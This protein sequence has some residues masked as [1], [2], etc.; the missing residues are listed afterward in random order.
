[1]YSEENSSG[2]PLANS[3]WLE[4]HHRAKI[5][6]RIAF[7]KRLEKLQPQKIVDLGCATGLWLE[8]LNEILP[9]D[10]EFIGIDSDV[11]SL[12]IAI[13]RS[14]S[15]SRK[16]S[17]MQLDIEKYATLIPTA[18][19]TLAFN[20]FPY[21]KDLDTFLNVL[22]TKTPHGTLA[23]RQYDGASIRFG[24]MPTSMR[25]KIEQDL[26][27]ATGNSEK[28][29]HYD[30]DRAFMALRNS[31]YKNFEYS[32]ELFERI[33]PFDQDFVPYYKGTMLW[34]CKHISDASAEFLKKWMNEDIHLLN[35]YFYEVDLVALLS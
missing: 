4:N 5:P 23:V 12:E 11:E 3:S 35:R 7:A 14:K 1:M 25:Q 32:F 15:W 13:S 16:T 6:E 29:R 19:L 8:L 21:I 22:A 20:I 31:A 27:L 18:D 9:L 24:P 34:T 10:C 2:K 26:H 28:F 17:F 30:L 33:S